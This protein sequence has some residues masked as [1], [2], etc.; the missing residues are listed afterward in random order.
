MSEPATEPRR[1]WPLFLVAAG[2]FLPGIG[3]LF[4]AVGLTWALI[5]DRPR[6][7]RAAVLAVAG[8][9]LNL[10]GVG[11]ILW[12][13]QS[14]PGYAMGMRMAAQQDLLNVVQALEAHRKKWR[15]YPER[16]SLLNSGLSLRPVNLNDV[17]VGFPA[18]PR[19]YIYL[20]SPDG[21]T[22]DLYGV[23]ADRQAGTPDDVRPE[24]PDSL[25]RRSGFRPAR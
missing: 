1:S 8:G 16:L 6:A 25:K 12:R 11:V 15:A 13:M 3:L 9:L 19:E 23:G 18:F 17:S 21:R 7:L 10:V 24:L 4:A 14:K 2:A 20:R 22:Y 5:S